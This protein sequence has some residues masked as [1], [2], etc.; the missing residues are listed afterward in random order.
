MIQV[1]APK[2]CGLVHIC[3]YCGCIFKYEA[4]D[5]YDKK[6]VY[7]PICKEKQEAALQ[8]GYDGVVREEVI[9]IKDEAEGTV[10]GQNC[11]R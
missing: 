11:C 7:C 8:V 4:S 5:V 3:D 10:N 1:I 9:E 2:C 6:Y